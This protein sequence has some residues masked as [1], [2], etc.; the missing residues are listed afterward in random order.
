VRAAAA[1]S[2][3]A[4]GATATA[5]QRAAENGDVGTLAALLAAQP[6]DIDARDELGRT[7]LMLAVL[8]GRSE[9]VATL[10]AHGAD[11][12]AADSQGTTPLQAA[13]RGEQAAI[14]QE[15]QRH[16]AR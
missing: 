3:A 14:V 16:G 13:Q 9:A 10:L 12:N 4:R 8:H 2:A 1:V 5:L 11:P 6:T 7:P 15:L